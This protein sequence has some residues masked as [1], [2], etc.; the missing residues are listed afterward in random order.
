MRGGIFLE[1]KK[2]ATQSFWTIRR[3]LPPE[4]V[5][6]P[7]FEQS[8]ISSVT[9]GSR[10]RVGQPVAEPKNSQAVALHASVSGEVTNIARFRHPSQ[11]ECQAIEITSDGRD[12]KLPDIGRERARWEDLSEE[13]LLNLFQEC[14]LVDLSPAMEAL[15]FKIKESRRAKIHTLILNAC[16]SEPYVSSRFALIMSHPL[17]VLKGAEILRR[18]FHAEK[19]VITI[20]DSKRE[21][22]EFLKSK[23]YFL[24]WKQAEVRMVPSL[25]PQDAD[26]PLL[27]EVLSLDAMDLIRG[28]ES[29]ARIVH[30]AT[31]FAVY[32]AVLLQ[33]PLYERV[34]TV[35]GECVVEPKN[36]WTRLGTS[37]GDLF[38]ACR[39]LLREPRKVV[40]NGPM[41]GLAQPD[42]LAPV[43]AGTQAVLALPKEVAI[44][45]KVE[46]CTRCQRCLEACP[47]E[48]SPAMITLAAERKLFEMAREWGADACIGCGN[49]AYVCPS[50]RPMVELIQQSRLKPFFQEELIFQDPIEILRKKKGRM[51]ET[52][53]SYD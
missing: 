47:V 2:E 23:I 7:F 20:E 42:L 39:G 51:A 38:K 3:P 29:G 44:P 16:E 36:L 21:A 17:E 30:A 22:A 34:V 13:S 53:V 10:V 4:K 5:L 1:P 35:A 48:V 33:K 49:C 28:K 27:Q 26:I 40:M 11:G 46:A 12:E 15:H 41:M 50:K 6:I 31:A 24:K 37:F 19:F 9:I 45:E 8:H 32:E 25:Y 43:I 18:L 52:R 14:G